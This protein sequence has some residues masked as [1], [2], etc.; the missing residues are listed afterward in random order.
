MSVKTCWWTGLNIFDISWCCEFIKGFKLLHMPLLQP[1]WEHTGGK[2]RTGELLGHHR[3]YYAKYS[4]LGQRQG[5]WLI[6]HKLLPY[7]WTHT[8]TC[9]VKKGLNADICSPCGRTEDVFRH[10]CSKMA[11]NVYNGNTGTLILHLI[12]SAIVLCKQRTPY[13]ILSSDRVTGKI[14]AGLWSSIILVRSLFR[15]KAGV[16]WTKPKTC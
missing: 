13:A 14:R 10:I 4:Q 2:A 12:A 9:S 5:A 6:G 8:G 16:V 3:T 15:N 7:L 1:T 11:G